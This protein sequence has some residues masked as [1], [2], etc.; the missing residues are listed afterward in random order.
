MEKDK[1]IKQSEEMRALHEKNHLSN[2]KIFH[3]WLGKIFFHRGE[4]KLPINKLPN[5]Q[6]YRPKRNGNPKL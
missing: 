3:G 2:L 6:Q 1:R 4:R 5:Y